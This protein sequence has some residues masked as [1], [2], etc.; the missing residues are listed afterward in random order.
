MILAGVQAAVAEGDGL[1]E[2]WR[3]LGPVMWAV[4]AGAAGAWFGLVALLG[5][6]LDPRRVA[7]GPATLDPPGDEPPAVVN[8]LATDWDLG[9]EAVPAT[10]VD[11]AARRHLEIDLVGG[12]T[13]VRLRGRR[14]GP[15]DP[16]T[17]YEEMVLAHVRHL[18]AQ[19]SDGRVPAAAMSTG[20]EHTSKSWWNRFRSAVVADAR[21][22]GL[23][24]PRWSPGLKVLLVGLA[25]P[26]ALAVSVAVSTLPD[27]PADSDDNPFAAAVWI[28]IVGFGLLSVVVGRLDG[29]R[30]TAAGRTAAARWLG[31][32]ELLGEDPLFGEQPPAAVAIWDRILAH[33]TAL[34]AAHGVV[35]ALPLGAENDRQAWSSVGGRWRVVRVRYPEAIPPGYGRHP[36]LAL[37]L[38]LLHLA[39]GIPLVPLARGAAS[40]V[41]D[42]VTSGQAADALGRDVPAGYSIAIT[43]VVAVVAVVAAG[44]SLRGAALTLAGLGDLVTGRTT[45]EGR[46]VRV[47]DRSTDDHV[48]VYVAVDDG[49]SDT[50]RAWLLRS[51]VGVAQGAIVRARVTRWLRHATEIQVVRPAVAPAPVPTAAASTGAP[52]GPGTGAP[53]RCPGRTSRPAAARFPVSCR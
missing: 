30:D 35:R 13:H 4:A 36:A 31:M 23:S 37:L 11:L 39:I 14:A 43:V 6:W 16:L 3:D 1:V 19:T 12:E 38:G 20:P 9:P 45:V 40:A 2:R 51:R 46:A 41:R 44:V 28:G 50:V 42:S 24:R 22:R 33:G 48:R 49:S 52:A 29:E 32:R 7:P 34:G 53:R 5:A 10:L 17:G 21:G 26:V 15:A 8:L 18:A 25:V 27:D 47:R